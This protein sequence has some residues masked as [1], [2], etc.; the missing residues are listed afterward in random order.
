MMSLLYVVPEADTK[1]VVAAPIQ[2][3]QMNLTIYFGKGLNFFGL[4]RSLNMN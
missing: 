4:D 3:M 2:A 1:Q